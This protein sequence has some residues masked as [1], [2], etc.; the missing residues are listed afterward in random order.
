[1]GHLDSQRSLYDA[2]QNLIGT[3]LS[4]VQNLVTLYKVLGGGWAES[5]QN[6]D[7]RSN[8]T[9]RDSMTPSTP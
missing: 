1:M 7:I 5:T 8:P 6:A 9:E 4:R 3:Q 2:Q